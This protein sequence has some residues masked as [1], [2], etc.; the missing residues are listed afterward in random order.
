MPAEPKPAAEQSNLALK[1]LGSPA[2]GSMNPL[3]E[4]EKQGQAIWLDYIRR[5]LLT[6]GELR[7]LVD[8]DG[9]SGVTSNP[10]IFEKA[11]AG[12]TD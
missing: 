5:N 2:E 12:S 3:R 1:G 4:V 7:W 9:L 11:I 10:T 8:E 6:S